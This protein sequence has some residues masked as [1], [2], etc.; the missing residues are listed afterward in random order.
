MPDADDFDVEYFRKLLG[1]DAG[2]EAPPPPPR[3]GAPAAKRAI[4]PHAARGKAEVP[5][6][7]RNRGTGRGR[8]RSRPPDERP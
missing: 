8:P 6:R 2:K 7:R 1:G 5:A 3:K 4:E